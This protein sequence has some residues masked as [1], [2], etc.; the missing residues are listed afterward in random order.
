MSLLFQSVLFLLFLVCSN[1]LKISQTT[2]NEEYSPQNQGYY[3]TWDTNKAFPFRNIFEFKAKG[4]DIYLATFEP[5]ATKFTHLFI[6]GGFNN[7]ET[8]L[9]KDSIGNNA[10]C[11]AKMSIQD[12]NAWNTFRVEFDPTNLIINLWYNGK[13]YL[14]CKDYNWFPKY[15]MTF[16][17]SQYAS[18]V[19]V[20]KDDQQ[21]PCKEQ[22]SPQNQGY[23]G[24]WQTYMAFP[25]R[26]I[27]EF[28][29]KGNDIYL[30]T[31]E[32]KATK[33]THLFIIGG[34]NNAETHLYKDVL[35]NDAVCSAKMKIQDLNA[36]NTFR[37][38][39]DPTNLTIN[40]WYNGKQYLSCKDPKW[41]PRDANDMSFVFSQYGSNV[42][43]CKDDQP[44]PKACARKTVP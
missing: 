25:F 2:C 34:W 7:A 37:V 21:N 31:F 22:Y 20:C 23:Y 40:L 29:A 5:K 16:I 12:L 3:G 36:W 24:I 14:S 8:H 13:Q 35:T 6:I 1:S 44:S 30:A 39:F 17:F 33:F 18:N 41:V 19:K 9:Y 32:P 11:S 26:N 15:D 38:E 4:N 27:Y 10:L 43:V 42:Q 28:R